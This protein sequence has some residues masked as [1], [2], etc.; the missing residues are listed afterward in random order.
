MLL[1]ASNIFAV[2]MAQPNVKKLETK[3]PDNVIKRLKYIED[4]DSEVKNVNKKRNPNTGQIEFSEKMIHFKTSPCELEDIGQAFLDD[5]NKGY[6][7]IHIVPNSNEK[8]SLKIFDKD[9]TH[10]T[11]IRTKSSQE[12][13]LLCTKNPVNPTLRDAYAIVWEKTGKDKV[14]GNIYYISSIRPDIYEKKSETSSSTFMIDGRVGYDLTDSLYVVYMAD[15][16]EELDQIADSAFI[17]YMPVVNKRFSFS[18]ELDKPKVGRIRTVMPDGS[19]CELW[20]NLDFVPGETYRITTHNGFYDGDN[21]YEM[22]V[23]RYSGKSLLNRDQIK[24]IDDQKEAEESHIVV[25]EQKDEF[26]IVTDNEMVTWY[27]SLNNKQKARLMELQARITTNG[28]ALKGNS[29][30]NGK[31]GQEIEK[32]FANGNKEVMKSAVNIYIRLCDDRNKIIKDYDNFFAETKA[33][34]NNTI[35]MN[36][37]TLKEYSKI[38][39]NL[40]RAK[41]TNGNKEE[42]KRWL[43]YVNKQ[44]KFYTDKLEKL[45]A[46][47]KQQ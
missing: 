21:D 14:E 34:S 33:P 16:A 10:A 36:Q 47:A 22:R 8:F 5:E 35:N 13:W 18:V 46:K 11:P 15:S 6:Q 23:G 2:A 44:V 41:D 27:N 29:M 28:D 42:W 19:L 26:F 9:D 39:Q 45:V 37:E 25:S 38:Q 31:L 32:D 12:M 43:D 40:I 24:G 7:L 1:V 17:A 30:G 4:Y 3:T 20:T